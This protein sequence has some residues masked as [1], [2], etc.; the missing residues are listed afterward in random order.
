VW[1]ARS[2]MENANRINWATLKKN[3]NKQGVTE[4]VV[5]FMP[6]LNMHEVYWY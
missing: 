1:L 5:N 3:T 4:M 6:V 2:M